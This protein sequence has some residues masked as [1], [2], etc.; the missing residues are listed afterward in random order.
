MW[1]KRNSDKQQGL[2]KSRQ[3]TLTSEMTYS[4]LEK[5]PAFTFSF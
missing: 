1:G 2:A 4:H 3:I 5:T